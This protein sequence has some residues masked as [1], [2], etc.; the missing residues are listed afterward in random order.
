[1]RRREFIAGLGGAAVTGR[2]AVR[3]VS[4]Q[5][6]PRPAHIGFISGADPA[7]AIDF[8]TALRDGLSMRGYVE[9]GTL[10]IE[11]LFSSY[12]LERIPMLLEQLERQHVNVIVTHAA[13]TDSVV[14]GRRTIPAIYEFS[15][16]PI[17]LGIA[18]GA[19][20][21]QPNWHHVDVG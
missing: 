16:D 21:L 15:A 8:L 1:M 4:A 13:A 14:K 12:D 5:G 20:A 3:A 9:P 6:A 10:K 11:Q 17:T 7:A 2:L 19:S 18:N